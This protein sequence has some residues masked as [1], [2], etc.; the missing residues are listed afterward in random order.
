M[1]RGRG[2]ALQPPTRLAHAG[3]R[4]EW[5]GGVV[6]PPVM[7]AS[8]VL[9][10]T[11]AEFEA[12][13]PDRGLYYARRG[14][15]SQW[16]LEE[17]LNALEP[18]AAGTAL[19]PSGVAAI[20]TAI[21]AAVGAGEHILLPDSAYQCTR[22]LAHGL[23]PR[24]GIEA[25][26]YDPLTTPEALAPAIRPTTRALF[27][28]TPGSLTFEVQDLEGLVGLARAQGLV[29]ILDNTWATPLLFDAYGHGVDIV[30]SA[31]TL[32]IGGWLVIN[33]QLTLGQLVAAELVIVSVLAATDKLIKQS[34]QV[35]DLLTALDK[36][37]HV[38]DLPLERV[39]GRELQPGPGGAGLVCRG[40]RFSYQPGAEVL[41]GLDLR[42]APGERISLVGLSGAG[43]STLA[44]LICGLEEPSHGTVEVNGMEVRSA[45]LESLRR[46]VSLVG[47]NHEIFAGTLEENLVVGRAHVTHED[48]RRALEIA[49][50]TEDLAT[51]PHGTRTMLVSGGRNISHGQAQRLLIA[52]A[53]VDRPQ[54]L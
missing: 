7:R 33:R 44:A 6:N 11:L 47:D 2:R 48:I 32:G 14:T 13:R 5:T 52:R 42:L 17:A 16:A 27:L 28:E 54:L 23:L 35:F 29:T 26:W 41:S 4:R 30:A 40:L 31:G 1:S 15:P 18:G 24:L 25:S 37:G 46:V 49:Q 3:R 21:L 43:K 22:D 9:F 20:T 36:V 12:A 39:D 38:T 50:L 19:F 10:P 34:E 45:R 8:T 51:L 53:I